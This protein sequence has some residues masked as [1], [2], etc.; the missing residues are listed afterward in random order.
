MNSIVNPITFKYSYCRK[1]IVL[2]LS[3]MLSYIAFSQE[4]Q[5]QKTIETLKSKISQTHG[6]AK[7]KWMDSLSN[8][9][10]Y[11]TDFESDSIVRATI[12]YAKKL[13]SVDIQVFQSANL[14]YYTRSI[15]GAPKEA[16]KII[17]ETQKFIAS[18]SNADVLAKYYF[19]V[20]STYFMLNEFKKSLTYL[21][22]CNLYASRTKN[23]KFIG[24]AKLTQGQVFADMGKF[25]DGSLKLQDAIKI[26]EAIKDTTNVLEARN[27]LAIIYSKN[28]F[29]EQAQKERNE[30]IKIEKARS[31]HDI[32]PAIFFNEAAD[33]NKIGKQKERIASLKLAAQQAALSRSS[34]F[35]TPI[36][37]FTLAGAYAEND[38]LSL[39][40][41]IREQLLHDPEKNT[42]GPFKDYY[43]DAE[44]KIAFAQNNFEDA[45]KFG[46]EYLL[47]KR[48]GKQYEEIQGAEHFLYKVYGQLGNPDKALKHFEA[49]YKIKDSIESVQNARIVSYYQTIYE[50][51]KREL[52]LQAQ[53]KNISLLNEQNKIRTQWFIT[54]TVLLFFTFLAL[55]LFRSRNF[56]KRKQKMQE[57][58]TQDILKAQEN[59]KERIA[60]ELHDNVGQKLMILKNALNKDEIHSADEIDL[61]GQTIREVREMSH[62]LHPFQFEKLGLVTSLQN[63]VETFQ[64]NSNVFYSHDIEITDEVIP[65][66]K[67]IYIFRMLQEGITNVEKHAN[68]TACNLSAEET[69]THVTFKLRD[70]GKG[71]K[72]QNDSTPNGLGMKTLK[73]RALFIGA[74]LDI[75][76]IPGKG[77]T[78]TIKIPKK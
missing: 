28:G 54:G 35:Y 20:G 64:K 4:N 70:N 51:E 47:L 26:F 12:S 76:S 30:I 15:K 71:F 25:G 53:E 23:D 73:E 72:V 50:T 31:T 74:L 63:M 10:A 38:S 36:I 61:V 52:Q 14:L 19:E 39:A 49:Y 27:S 8:F 66:E 45:K 56:A 58:F 22:S 65:K 6:S 13:D 16:E 17:A 9:I 40:K 69:K 34:A 48:K 7:L 68:A 18:V 32:L 57:A 67:G 77:T 60:T 44:K 3:L 11:N 29:Y 59:E 21:D 24:L 62:N 55:W 2:L 43:L 41:N 46:E 5:D 1:T 33:Y 75:H 42:A 37:L 78:L